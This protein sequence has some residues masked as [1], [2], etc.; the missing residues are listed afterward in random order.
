MSC[1]TSYL[2]LLLGVGRVGRAGMAQIAKR[3]GVAALPTVLGHRG[4][5]AAARPRSGSSAMAS[6]SQAALRGR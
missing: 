4:I 2:R 1:V 3:A 5:S 6:Q